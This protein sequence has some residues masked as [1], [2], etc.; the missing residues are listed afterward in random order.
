MI[1]LIIKGK[2]KSEAA[3]S[4]RAFIKHVRGDIRLLGEAI[5]NMLGHFLIHLFIEQNHIGA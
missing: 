1:H 3:Q 4:Y 2:A 5:S